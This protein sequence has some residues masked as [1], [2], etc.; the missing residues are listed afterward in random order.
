MTTDIFE[1]YQGLK[2]IRRV[3]LDGTMIWTEPY[4]LPAYLAHLDSYYTGDQ[5]LTKLRLIGAHMVRYGEAADAIKIINSP[6]SADTALLNRITEEQHVVRVIQSICNDLSSG[7]MTGVFAESLAVYSDEYANALVAE[8]VVHNA[9][10]LVRVIQNLHGID[11][12]ARVDKHT[13]DYEI[14]VEFYRNALTAHGRIGRH[15]YDAYVLVDSKHFA[16]D[17]TSRVGSHELDNRVAVDNIQYALS[18]DSETPAHE[19]DNLVDVEYSHNALSAGTVT[20]EHES[21]HLVDIDHVDRAVS[22]DAMSSAYDADLALEDSIYSK[23]LDA[24]AKHGVWED[25]VFVETGLVA[26]QFNDLAAICVT[27]EYDQVVEYDADVSVAKGDVG[28]LNTDTAAIVTYDCDSVLSTMLWLF[29][30]QTNTDLYIPMLYDDGV[31]VGAVQNGVNLDM[32]T[33]TS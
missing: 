21:S 1:L 15:S 19:L 17:A 3:Y 23:L 30:V 6:F 24:T 9:A 14:L 5:F 7:L 28:G 4:F 32:R 11:A 10:E 13:A 12:T 2:P 26:S 27:D 22:V 16:S 29:P 31:V 25:E 8:M 20:P 18:A 33:S